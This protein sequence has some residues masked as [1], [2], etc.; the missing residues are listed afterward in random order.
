MNDSATEAL[1]ATTLAAPAPGETREIAPG[2]LWLRMP[3]PFALDHVNLWLIEEAD[4]H[5]L[6][7][8]GYGDAATRAHWQ[9][10]FATTLGRRPLRRIVATHCHPDHL[11]NAAWLAAHFGCPIL[12]TQAEY[13]AAH[14][15]RDE[16]AGFGQ[17]DVRALF[18]SHGMTTEHLEAFTARGNQYRR[19]VPEAPRAFSR[20]VQ[21]DVLAL[22]PWRWRVVTGY[23]HSPEHAS[24]AAEDARLLISGDMLLPRISTN[25]AVWP[26]EPEGDPVARFL[27]SLAAFEALPADTLVLPSHGPPFRGIAARVAQLRRHHA[28][29]LAELKRALE[30]ADAPQSAQD[31]VPVLFRRELDTQQRFFAMGE[32]IAHLNHLW[33]HGRIERQVGND[34]SI[35]Y[36]A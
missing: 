23:G 34:G 36:A 21:G 35:R 16:H 20:L 22:G 2:V 3:L 6:V 14:A 11:G 7:D 9:R 13:L 4:G 24:L 19:G 5:T 29:R 32:A 15:L 25:V 26:G 33:R 30:G 12:M 17:A 8:C 27:A 28:E 31:L 18:A 10:H 1:V